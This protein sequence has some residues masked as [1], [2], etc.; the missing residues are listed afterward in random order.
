MRSTSSWIFAGCLF[1]H[2]AIVVACA[3]PPTMSVGSSTVTVGD[4]IVVRFDRPIGGMA[5]NLHW[6]TLLP[7]AS[8]DDST[9]GRFIVDHGK[10]MVTI[11]TS[12]AGAGSFEVRLYDEYPSKDHHL[13]ARVPVHVVD[14]AVRIGAPQLPSPR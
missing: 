2:A 13:I 1:A 12:G 3:Q 5:S 14:R 6:M 10:T 7:V 9:V 8:P 11:P 4:E